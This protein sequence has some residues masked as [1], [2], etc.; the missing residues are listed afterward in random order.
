M[1]T[2]KNLFIATVNGQKEGQPK[3][4]QFLSFV[5]GESDQLIEQGTEET[6]NTG[7]EKPGQTG[8]VTVLN[9]GGNDQ[10]GACAYAPRSSS[11]FGAAALLLLGLLGLARA[12]RESEEA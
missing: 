5:P 11:R 3:N 9:E 2:V 10:A 1:P 6:P 12:R 8:G 7:T 4:A